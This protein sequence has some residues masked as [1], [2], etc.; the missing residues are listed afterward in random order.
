MTGAWFGP[1]GIS[2]DYCFD[3]A[4]FRRAQRPEDQAADL[5][6]HLARQRVRFILRRLLSR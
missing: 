6:R 3:C 1:I 4:E 2:L 5:Y